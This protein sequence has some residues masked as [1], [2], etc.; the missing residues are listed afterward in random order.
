MKNKTK[1]TKEQKIAL[2]ACVGLSV[3]YPVAHGLI[4]YVGQ[5]KSDPSTEERMDRMS[6]NIDN[7]INEL[8]EFIKRNK[9]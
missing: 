6:E 9:I 3:T 1:P 7:L 5:E 8:D 4:F 2:R